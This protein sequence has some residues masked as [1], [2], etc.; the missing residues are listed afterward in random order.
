MESITNMTC[1]FIKQSNC[2]GV[3]LYLIYFNKVPTFSK[4]R[5]TYSVKLEFVKDRAPPPLLLLAGPFIS[6]TESTE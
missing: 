2:I 1:K 5:N 6:E 3:H 4:E